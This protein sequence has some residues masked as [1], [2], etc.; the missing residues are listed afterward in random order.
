MEIHTFLGMVDVGVQLLS[1]GASYGNTNIPGDGGR[2]RAAAVHR[3]VVEGHCRDMGTVAPAT[4]RSKSMPPKVRVRSA[5]VPRST[6]VRNR[7]LAP[8]G[9][10]LG[11]RVV[12]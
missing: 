7:D 8:S 3:D 5:Y 4:N 12:L 1:I 10:L 11:L 6:R 2:G 9:H